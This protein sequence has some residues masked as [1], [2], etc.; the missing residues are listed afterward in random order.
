VWADAI[1]INQSDNQ[2]KSKQVLL[3]GEIYK[4]ASQVVVELGMTCTNDKHLVCRD[5]LCALLNMLSLTART[6]A[7][8][9]PD[10][11][12]LHTREYGRFG[13]PSYGYQAW[14]AWRAMRSTSWFTRSWIV[15]EVTAGRNVILLYNGQ[16]FRWEDIYL[17]N[18][19]TA[20]EQVDLK[21][22][23]GKM[24]IQN[25]DDLQNTDK[26]DLPT[27]LDLLSIS[28]TLNAT[29]P[30]DKIYAFHGLAS[31]ENPPYPTMPGRWK[32][33]LSISPASLFERVSQAASCLNQRGT[34]RFGRSPAGFPTGATMSRGR[35]TATPSSLPGYRSTVCGSNQRRRKKTLRLQWEL[36]RAIS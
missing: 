11:K 14:G 34:E 21:T 32:R 25:M 20:R 10:E 8:V 23:N 36:S 7:A 30:R 31:D 6:L 29:D 2:E 33:S 17:A 5:Y 4:R 15:Q 3:M 26:N 18:G 16:S 1:C 12:G 9:R 27:L 19:V 35:S 24:N 22:Y 13:I 28:R